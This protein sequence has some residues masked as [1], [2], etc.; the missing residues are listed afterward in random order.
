MFKYAILVLSLTSSLWSQPLAFEYSVISKILEGGQRVSVDLEKD[1]TLHAYDEIRFRYTLDE[2]GYFYILVFSSDGHYYLLH[3]RNT[4]AGE[5]FSTEWFE[6][7]DTIGTETIHFI[8]STEPLEALETLLGRYEVADEAEKSHLKPMIDAKIA[9]SGEKS[10]DSV[11]MLENRL[12]KSAEVGATYR[13]MFAKKT[14]H[15]KVSYRAEG[16]RLA[17][18]V[19]HIDHR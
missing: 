2:R 1:A 12:T 19:F 10:D 11:T 3:Q 15:P 14:Q 16:E 8:A 4:D 17:S 5:L 18:D 13:S 7:D 9:T 6:L